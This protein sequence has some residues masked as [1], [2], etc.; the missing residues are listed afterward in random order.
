MIY[1]VYIV[2]CTDHSLYTGFTT[3]LDRRVH[4]HN[5]SKLGAK[6]IKGKLPVKLIYHEKFETKSEALKREYEIKQFKREEKLKLI[7]MSS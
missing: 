3:D 7:Q 6:S 2:E 1:F 5:N 4:E